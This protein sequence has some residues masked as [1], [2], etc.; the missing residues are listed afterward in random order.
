MK[1]IHTITAEDINK[2]M[3][4]IT[5]RCKHCGHADTYYLNSALG[6]VMKIDIGKRVYLSNS[7]I[8]CVESNEQMQQRLSRTI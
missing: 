2:P 1:Y 4:S 5:V 7:G 3:G 8:I 6:R